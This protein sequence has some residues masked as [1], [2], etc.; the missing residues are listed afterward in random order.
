MLQDDG[1]PGPS[2]PLG[3]EVVVESEDSTMEDETGNRETATSKRIKINTKNILC[4]HL[5]S[6]TTP[7][8]TKK[9]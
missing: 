6:E 2:S 1:L 9:K 3:E 4:S 5:T 7:H 8:V